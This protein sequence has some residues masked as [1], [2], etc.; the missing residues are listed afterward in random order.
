V[1]ARY[2]GILTGEG[3]SFPR[4][5][6]DGTA[7]GGAAGMFELTVPPGAR[8]PPAHS[9]SNNDEITYCLEGTLRISVGD[10]VRD[11]KPGEWGYTPRG[12]TH[13]FSNPHDRAARVL[14]VLTPDIG[15]QYFRDVAEVVG[16]PGGPSP[17][18]IAEVISRYGLVLSPPKH[19]GTTG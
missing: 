9:H 4:N 13:G 16:L 10:E 15:A 8:V 6:V 18:K 2:L 7:N 5:K 19:A 11:L 14:V 1:T 17:A 3:S 12:V